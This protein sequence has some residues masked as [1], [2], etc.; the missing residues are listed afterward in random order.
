MRK[1]MRA[2]GTGT[3]YKRGRTW[4]VEVVLGYDVDTGRPDRRTKGG[5][6]TKTAALAYVPTLKNEDRTEQKPRSLNHY[7]RLWSASAM[8]KLSDSKQTA[9]RIA[10]G[11]WSKVKHTI[12]RNLDVATL[13]EVIDAQAPTYYPARDMRTL[14][15][16]LFKLAIADEQ[17]TV[18]RASYITIPP[19][20]EGEPESFTMAEVA[21]FWEHFEA[22]DLFIGYPLLMIYSGMMP[23]ELFKFEKTMID[24][25]KQEIFGCGI[26][27]RERKRKPIVLADF[28]IPVLKTLCDAAPGKKVL[29][30]NHDNFYKEFKAAL[31]RCG[32]RELPPYSCRHT[33]ATALAMGNNVA[34]TVIQRVMRHTKFSTTQRYIHP[35]NAS[36]L[37]AVNTMRK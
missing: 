37:A 21:S 26:K 25:E 33:T 3:A 9:Y 6:P 1:K 27:T 30:M 19:L 34:A 4:T 23:G 13:Q 24:W 32:C 16:H 7:W 28:I 29:N 11:K 8:L 36:A 5:F 14:L 2:N 35:D 17:I 10:W 18:N 22:G 15:S 31:E 12:I 20:D